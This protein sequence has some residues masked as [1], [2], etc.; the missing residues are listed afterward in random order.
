MRLSRQEFQSA[1]YLFG[2][3]V[4]VASIPLSNYF[5]SLA[6]WLLVANFF[7]D[8][9]LKAK[10]KRLWNNKAA[11]II[12]GIFVMH[13]VGM[14][15]TSDIQYAL[16]DI[17][18]KLPLLILP[19]ILAA[20]SPLSSKGFRL[21]LFT[22][23]LAVTVGSLYIVW[24]IYAENISDPRDAS[25]LISHIRFALNI[26]MALFSL[27]Y[28]IFCSDKIKTGIRILLVADLLWLFVFLF[29][30]R[31]FTGLA[32]FGITLFG[33]SLRAMFTRRSRLLK[34]IIGSGVLVISALLI[35]WFVIFYR[36]NFVGETID[37]NKLDYYTSRGNPYINNINS[38]QTENGNY[39]WIYFCEPELRQGW[40][41][42]STIDYDS[43]DRTGQPLQYT[44]VRFLTSKGLR[45]DLDGIN[46]LTEAEI[47]SIE[48]GVANIDEIERPGFIRRIE[49]V[50]WEVEDYRHI[51][52]PTNHSLMQRVELWKAAILIIKENPFAGVGTGDVPS[53]FESKLKEI[54]SPL[55]G[56]GL[57]T[58]DQYLAITVAFG[59]PGLLFF[60][61]ALIYAPWR[62]KRFSTYFFFSFFI[63]AVLSMIT[64]DMLE[65][66]PGVS[67]FMF[68]FTLFLFAWQPDKKQLNDTPIKPPGNLSE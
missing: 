6:Q 9:N 18:I 21:I 52:D 39:L 28:Y 55:Y 54:N 51:G 44:L 26:C 3:M 50:I 58:H 32:V 7:I 23:A 68:F 40:N 53:A 59:I 33:L 4:F 24:R 13:V 37:A 41:Q 25:S 34:I 38:A 49:N 16:K 42:R 64:E 30:L 11:L 48:N 47:Y 17:R 43:T 36:T 15:W 10:L 35:I 20:E 5:M 46:S 45:K 60:L 27:G 8:Y 1:I 67:F 66:Q 31:S 29:I 2:L 22:H 12:I 62:Q 63:I 65:S 57:R 56:A 61:F 19:F 14:I